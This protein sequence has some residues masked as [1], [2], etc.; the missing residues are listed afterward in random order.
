MAGIH[1]SSD[2]IT[3]GCVSHTTVPHT[4]RGGGDE[5]EEEEHDKSHN[6]VIP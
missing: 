3:H 2:Y 4:Q 1:S 5:E 6:Q